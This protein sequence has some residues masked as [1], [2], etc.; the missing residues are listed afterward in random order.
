[1]KKILIYDLDEINK[2]LTN[3]NG[4]IIQ[5][6]RN[7]FLS[8]KKSIS[9]LDYIEENSDKIK[10][11]YLNW[12]EEIS[13]IKIKNIPIYKKLYIRGIYS[14]WW[15]TYFIEKSNS[16]HSPHIVDAIKLIALQEWLKGREVNQISIFSSNKNLIDCLKD[17]SRRKE[18]NFK[19]KKYKKLTEIT[20]K[21][22]VK[23]LPNQIKAIIWLLRKIYYSLPLIKIGIEDY[24]NN[25]SNLLFVDYL[26]NLNLTKLENGEFYSN[27]WC[28]L[29]QALRKKKVK[30][31][32]IHLSIDLG[33]NKTIFKNSNAIAKK[34]KKFN[35]SSKGYESHISLD[36]FLSIQLIKK[37]ILDWIELIF[38]AKNINLNSNIKLI[39]NLNLW[40][41]FKEEWNESI[42]G[43][44]S[45]YNCLI[46]N[47]FDKAFKNHKEN[48]KLIYLLENQTWEF[49]MIQAWRN[50][51]KGCLIGYLHASIS[52]W[53]LR[54]FFDHKTFKNSNFPIPDKFALNGNLSKSIFEYNVGISNRII[55]LE[56]TRYNY[57]KNLKQNKKRI[58]NNIYKKN[59][60]IVCDYSNVDTE[61]QLKLLLE[62]SEYLNSNF[63]V[64]IKPHP[65]RYKS[66]SIDKKL[67][68]TVTYKSI[69]ELINE[70]D[71]VFTSNTT[72][73]ALEFYY[74]DKNI[75]SMINE[76]SL[77]LSPLRGMDDVEFIK[78]SKE[79]LVSLKKYN[80]RKVNNSKD[81]DLFYLNNE[82]PKWLDLLEI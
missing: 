80:V 69:A 78:N 29:N 12:I 22:L 76:K 54:K 42:Y 15:Q 17:F 33:R 75:I 57:L 49:A 61:K 25:E 72:S 73:A 67:R 74:L 24:L 47:L 58:N 13:N 77:N 6:N 10:N 44:T 50:N 63:D 16:E 28:E 20:L 4:L 8:N 21:R 32:W 18:L 5:W 26:I 19:F 11:L 68:H 30:S 43:V 65:G 37:T 56:A 7:I 71:V 62:I 66:I 9:I 59:L 52:Y 64:K 35:I 14:Y 81:I 1:M 45:I 36:S 60:L 70:V 38:K 23:L 27:Y 41:L 31:K 53:D 39:D 3:F 34:L 48:T 55:K 51:P 82:F 46:F 79:L 40:Y 2:D